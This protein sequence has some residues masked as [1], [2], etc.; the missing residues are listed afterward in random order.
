[1]FPEAGLSPPRSPFPPLVDS[2]LAHQNAS[3]GDLLFSLRQV[4][5]SLGSRRRPVAVGTARLAPRSVSLAVSRTCSSH[6]CPCRPLPEMSTTNHSINATTA[7]GWAEFAAS[8]SPN[9]RRSRAAVE[10]LQH[11]LSEGGLIFQ[12]S[13]FSVSRNEN[14]SFSQIKLNSCAPRLA[15]WS[16]LPP[17]AG[18]IC[19][20]CRSECKRVIAP[21]ARALLW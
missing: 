11:F 18:L 17:V 12:S 10:D 6:Q 14:L 2:V 21:R 8:P 4:H 1:M 13:V 3:S 7:V 19:N 9:P 15:W 16:D 5:R 20:S